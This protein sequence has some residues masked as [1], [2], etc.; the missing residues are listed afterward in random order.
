[1]QKMTLP[2]GRDMFLYEE[3][4][5]DDI[6]TQHTGS[7][8]TGN[9]KMTAAQAW[10][11]YSP[12]D[13]HWQI[14]FQLVYYRFIFSWPCPQSF[15]GVHPTKGKTPKRRA[16][17]RPIQAEDLGQA[18]ESMEP[19]LMLGMESSSAEPVW[20][21][22]KKPAAAVDDPD[23]LSQASGRSKRIKTQK[24]HDEDTMQA[25]ISSMSKLETRLMFEARQF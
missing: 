18:I 2:T 15:K 24:D 9:T 6:T 10:S 23:N 5:E 13:F 12:N 16:H 8:V 20:K 17:C 3:G 7:T 11:T 25:I 14:V 4:V 21:V 1:M 22:V 19:D